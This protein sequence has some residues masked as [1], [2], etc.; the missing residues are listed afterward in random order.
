ME[1]VIVHFVSMNPCRALLHRGANNIN[2][3]KLDSEPLKCPDPSM[4]YKIAVEDYL[5]LSSSHII[6]NV[7]IV[8]YVSRIRN[9]FVSIFYKNEMGLFIFISWGS[10]KCPVTSEPT[11]L[12]L[13]RL[14][15][16]RWSGIC[17]G[18]SAT[19][20]PAE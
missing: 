3:N 19:C 7:D 6:T 8:E 17:Q 12:S 18:S 11:S 20:Y 4:V 10:R 14:Q 13:K 5:S 2:H 16:L 1:S 15:M 9:D